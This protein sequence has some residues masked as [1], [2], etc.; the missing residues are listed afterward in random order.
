MQ[1]NLEDQLALESKY[2]IETAQTEDYSEG[3][4]A[5]VEKRKPVFKG[6]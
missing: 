1:N 5:F 2:Q 3:V 4:N 6:K